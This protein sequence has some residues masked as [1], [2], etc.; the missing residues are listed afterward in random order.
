VIR[1]A[2]R[3]DTEDITAH[4]ELLAQEKPFEKVMERFGICFL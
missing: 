1:K 4:F 2:L 3:A